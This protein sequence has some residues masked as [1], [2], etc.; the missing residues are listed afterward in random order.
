MCVLEA[1]YADVYITLLTM[2]L[3]HFINDAHTS[4]QILP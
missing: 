2:H 1:V 3:V 4:V